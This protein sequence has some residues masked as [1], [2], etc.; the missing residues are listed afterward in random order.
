MQLRFLQFV[1]VGILVVPAGGMARADSP[2][3]ICI[4]AHE[5]A[6]ELRHRSRLSASREHWLM[7]AAEACPDDIRNE[8][9]RGVTEINAAMPTILFEARDASNNDLSEVAVTMDGRPLLSRLEG[10]AIVVDP[11]E[12]EFEFRSPNLPSAH[13]RLVIR[14]GEKGRRER[15]NLGEPLRVVS[16][17]AAPR[18]D[19]LRDAEPTSHTAQRVVGTCL[20]IGGIASLG[21]AVVDQLIAKNREADSRTAA[22]SL[23][24]AVQAT[25][26]PLHDQAVR[27]QTYAIVFGAVGAAA[28]GAG[29]YLFISSVGDSG[30]GHDQRAQPLRQL[31]PSIQRGS[32][33]LN[34]IQTY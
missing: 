6:L 28:L 10:T 21:I 27:S 33:A 8:C 2:T 1:I 7:C 22:A 5:R 34:F 17:V 15:V 18:Q 19:V 13:T 30:P 25:A 29:L 3:A 12:H 14:E 11:G 16:P 26:L 32:I 23:D 4:D 9:A 20:G 31:I 24:P